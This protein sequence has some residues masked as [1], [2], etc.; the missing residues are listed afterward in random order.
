MPISDLHKNYLYLALTIV[1]AIVVTYLEI[2]YVS[3]FEVAVAFILTFTAFT[4][5]TLW[6]YFFDKENS[7]QPSKS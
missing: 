7:K 2:I 1:F 4:L 5:I 6:Y 3:A